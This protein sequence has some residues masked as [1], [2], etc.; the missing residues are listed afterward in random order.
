[1]CISVYRMKT[2]KGFD[3][4][5]CLSSFI[6]CFSFH[7]VSLV[8]LGTK[9]VVLNPGKDLVLL[10]NRLRLTSSSA[11]LLLK[12]DS[13]RIRFH[14]NS[15]FYVDLEVMK[16][17]LVPKYN[18]Y[19]AFYSNENHEFARVDG[20]Q[21]VQSKHCRYPA[22]NHY[23]IKHELEQDRKT[24]VYPATCFEHSRDLCPRDVAPGETYYYR[25]LNDECETSEEPAICRKP[26]QK[27]WW[28]SQSY[29]KLQEVSNKLYCTNYT[30]FVTDIFGIKESEF[31]DSPLQTFPTVDCATAFQKCRVCR[32]GCSDC[33][34]LN[35]LGDRSC[36]CCYKDCLVNCTSYYR[37]S[38][39][40]MP[41]QCAKGDTSRFT[42]TMN[43]PTNLNLQFNCFLEYT[44]PKTLY[45]LK[46]KVKHKAGRFSSKWITKTFDVP[47]N[48]SLATIQRGRNRLDFL[49][50]SHSTNFNISP[51]LYLQGRRVSVKEPYEYSVANLVGP[52]TTLENA[53]VTKTIRVQ[54]K[55]PFPITTRSWS[56]G[57][58]C[59]KLS[60]WS[61]TFRNTFHDLLSARVENVGVKASGEIFYHIYHPQRLPRMNISISKYESI[62]KYILKKSTI[63]NDETFQGRLYLRNTTWSMIISGTLTSCPGFFTLQIIDEV[64]EVKVLE[65]DV[66][67]LCPE[68]G[69]EMEI[70]I[71]RKNLQDKERLFSI[72][73]FNSKQ[74]LKFQL[75]LVD[76]DSRKRKK[77]IKKYNDEKSNPWLTLMPLFVVTGCVLL[78]LLAIMIY[79]QIS[80]KPEVKERPPR[81]TFIEYTNKEPKDG[82]RLKRRHLI[83]IVFLVVVRIVYSFVFTLS[84]AFAILTLLHGHNLK[85]I[86]EYQDFVQSK[87]DESNA[88]ALRMDQHREG[89]V[90]RILEA[91][92]DIERSC[93]FFLGLQLQWLRFNITCIIQENHLKIF[94]KLSKKIAKRVTEEIQSLKKEIEERINVFEAR[95][96]RKLEDV[97]T[98]LSNYGTRVYDNKWFIL[99]KGTYNIKD[100]FERKKRDIAAIESRI[101]KQ[102][103]YE[104]E[105]S[106][107]L[108]RHEI[109]TRMKRSIAD[110]SFIG[111]L[112]YVG[113][114]DLD[115]FVEIENNFKSKIQFAKDG[116]ADFT[117]VLKTGKSPEHPFAII[118]MCPLRFMLNYTKEQ[119]K[120]GIREIK[121]EGEEWAK[122]KASCFVGNVSDFFAANTSTLD[123]ILQTTDF[124]ERVIYENVHGLNV[125]VNVSQTN[126]SSLIESAR[127]G[128]F[129][130]IEEGDILEEQVD[131]QKREFLEKEGKIHNVTSAYDAEVFLVT[132]KAVLSV[133]YIIDILIL[134]YRG[135][136]TYHLVI[137]LIEGF[138][139][140]V[141]HDEDEFQ[142]KPP[143]TKERG[144]RLVR[145]GLDVLAEAF[146]AFLTFCKALH[147]KIMLT[148]MI[149]GCIIIAASAAV[150]YLLIAVVFNVMNVTVIEELGGYDLIAS[151]LDTD[152]NFTNLAI[153]D[154]VDF[155][156]NNELRLYKESVNKTINEYNKMI[157]NFNK[158]QQER[159]ETF[160]RQLCS[161]ESDGNTCF[162]KIQALTATLLNFN[163]ESCLIPTLEGT[164]YEN[165]DGEAY[166]QRLKQGSKRFVDAVRNIVLETIFFI[167]GVALLI[168]I[169]TFLSFVV[170][171]FLKSRGM[172]RVKEVH[173]YKVLPPHKIL[174]K[175]NL[176]FPKYD[177]DQGDEKTVDTKERRK[178]KVPSIFVSKSS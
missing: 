115:K 160:K 108:S 168:I 90:K 56:N 96:K 28:G 6:K 146:S 10:E 95:T 59:K 112:D 63:R 52:N 35:N 4:V 79:A 47:N 155:I 148:N 161:L 42:L 130:N 97:E 104:K 99:P 172:V 94:N 117:E 40:Q 122:S 64:D 37:A 65:Q 82:N 116:L 143:S 159:I 137:S 73:L 77:T 12:R 68:T 51:F 13:P 86:Q 20:F 110:N 167:M 98:S 55:T 123:Y 45:T 177:E 62:F 126:K 29:C 78:G 93:D 74:K 151:R 76:K 102:N 101:Q 128:S 111:F 46:Y 67:I 140:I 170:F 84:V 176:E 66:V 173:L 131:R 18:D 2:S 145:R 156:N 72:L 38:C 87:I 113:V 43:K 138:E 119:L 125:T 3:S 124:S 57:K 174:R 85:T 30:N 142:D 114:V 23:T 133:I 71:P 91:V 33:G 153:V 5:L 16:V 144:A 166:R 165:Y 164:P 75:A 175:F 127:G 21:E 109:L 152:Y 81:W 11:T 135:S 8:R 80:H 88:M 58:N 15:D 48:D 34:K 178:L 103:H 83:L 105:A 162:K 14:R 157:A 129:F 36:S 106:S 136:K 39:T 53:H 49:D 132:R 70:H 32:D 41:K 147:K 54:T 141:E 69:F 163:I 50:V 27:S 169:I 107:G 31:L 9:L 118:L 134:I 60:E 154:Q 139:E 26:H 150:I 121:E 89:E 171:L 120:R 92:E 17:N 1:M 100:K 149:P 22:P 158:G 44:F 19:D 61:Q 25:S 7:F 24:K